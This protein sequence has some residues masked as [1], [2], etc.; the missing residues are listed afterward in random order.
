MEQ[1]SGHTHTQEEEAREVEEDWMKA[2]GAVRYGDYVDKRVFYYNDNFYVDILST[3]PD[4]SLVQPLF[5]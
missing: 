5:P 4:H 1:R 3:T 2:A